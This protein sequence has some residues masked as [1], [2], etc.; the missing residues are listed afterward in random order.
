[1]ISVDSTF[2][3]GKYRGVLLIATGVDGENRL[4]PLT[5]A[6]VES[7]NID[8]WSWFLHL[9][10]R[11]VVGRLRKVCIVSDLHQGILSVVEDYMEG[12]QPVVS[13]SC[14]RHFAA[15]IWHRQANKKVREQLKSAKAKRTFN[16]RLEKLKINDE[17]GSKRVVGDMV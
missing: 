7:E 15:N 3:T 4:V 10:R 1:V 12:Y 17:S 13:H 5:F 14:M 2:L 8:S 11:D 6:L 9:V 16:I